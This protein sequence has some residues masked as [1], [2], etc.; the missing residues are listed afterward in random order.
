MR[1]ALVAVLFGTLCAALPAQNSSIPRPAGDRYAYSI[2]YV[3]KNDVYKATIG[4]SK[5]RIESYDSIS[6]YL[7]E[8]LSREIKARGFH[9]AGAADSAAFKFTID[10]MEVSDNQTLGKQ[11]SPLYAGPIITVQAAISVADSAG[12]LLYRKEF[13]GKAALMGGHERVVTMAGRAVDELMLKFDNDQDL[14]KALYVPGGVTAKNPAPPAPASQE[15]APVQ[16]AVSALAGVTLP[17]VPASQATTAPAQ[18]RLIQLPAGTAVLLTLD[19]DFDPDRAN[20]GDIISF[21]L[22]DDLR[23]GAVTVASAGVK[24]K[25]SFYREA[26]SKGKRLFFGGAGGGV[27]SSMP[28][29]DP[30]IR[31]GY[32]EIGDLRVNLRS[33]QA[34]SKEQSLAPGA[35]ILGSVR[36]KS[37]RRGWYFLVD[38]GTRFQ[39]YTAENVNLP[40]VVPAAQSDQQTETVPGRT[41][42]AVT[43]KRGDVFVVKDR[44]D[45]NFLRI[46]EGAKMSNA[47]LPSGKVVP[48]PPAG[49]VWRVRKGTIVL[50]QD[51]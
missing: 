45:L 4:F 27:T 37:G 15:A 51:K 12:N 1:N 32:L 35:E 33:E 7:Q 30:H 23:V 8:R 16:A 39:A 9:L 47:T 43:A 21:T 29:G 5:K 49:M 24:A 28:A 26:L 19:Q 22:A 14:K 40:I 11:L 20:E 42:G 31:M 48:A 13:V 18:P 25:G 10:L 2:Q 46:A 38:K 50:E 44:R 34:Q 17:S 3:Q 41:A 36:K 6:R